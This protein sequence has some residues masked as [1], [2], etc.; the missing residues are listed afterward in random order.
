MD[1]YGSPDACSYD[2]LIHG[3]AASGRLEDA[4]NVFDEMLKR[5][6]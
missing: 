4:M 1:K 3:C 6:L 5:G 2:L